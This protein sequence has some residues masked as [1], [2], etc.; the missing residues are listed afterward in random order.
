MEEQDLKL[1]FNAIE[2]G[3]CLAFLGAG[4]ST[5]FRKNA[6]EEVS[7]LPAGG[8]LAQWLAAKC[9]YINGTTYDLARVAEHFVYQY[10]GDRGNLIEALREKIQ[11]SCLPRPIHTVLA[12]LQKIK[13]LI[14]SNY[15]TLLEN[16]LSKYGRWLTKHVYN[17]QN[18]RT[19][20][21]LQ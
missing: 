19:G 21:F 18:S 13:V 3:K 5:S 7:G 15:D 11:I 6:Q 16:E 14:T 8:E 9:Q 2:S 10:S 1:I 12:Q 17:P 20:H 4:V